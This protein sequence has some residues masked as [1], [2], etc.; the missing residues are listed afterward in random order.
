MKIE[1]LFLY[2]FEMKAVKFNNLNRE[3]F[4]FSVDNHIM[5]F[6]FDKIHLDT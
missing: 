3:N 6:S 5:T 2:G 4:H 1:I